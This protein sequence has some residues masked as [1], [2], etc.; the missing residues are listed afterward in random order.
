YEEDFSSLVISSV[1][2]LIVDSTEPTVASITASVSIGGTVA[3]T[4][5]NGGSGYVGTTTSISISAPH[6]LGVGVGTT[7]TA[8]ATITNGVITGTTITNAG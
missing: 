8:T 5:V 7:A 2:G 4:I 6:S 1:G 3:L